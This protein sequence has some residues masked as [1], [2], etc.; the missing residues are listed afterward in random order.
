MRALWFLGLLLHAACA[1]GQLSAEDSS[2]L[3]NLL[4]ED[5]SKCEVHEDPIVAPT[6][7]ERGEFTCTP[8]FN[9]AEEHIVSDQLGEFDIRIGNRIGFEQFENETKLLSHSECP[10]YGDVCCTTVIPPTP[11]PTPPPTAEEVVTKC[12]RGDFNCTHFSR[13]AE[14][15]IV[16]DQLGNFDPRIGTR[17][18]LTQFQQDWQALR[19]SECTGEEEICCTKSMPALPPTPSYIPRCGRRNVDG[20]GASIG[21]F[22]GG[23]AQFGEF[24]WM[25]AVQQMETLPSGEQKRFFVCG[26]ALI[27]PQL[28]LTAAHCVHQLDAAS[29]VVRLGEWDFRNKMELLPHV[30]VGVS[31]IA[32]HPEYIRRRLQE[33]VAV[34]TLAEPVQLQPH[35]DT[36][37]LP[38]PDVDYDRA[39]CVAPGW[40][41]QFGDSGLFQAILK[42]TSWQHLPRAACMTELRKTP[43]LRKYFYLD[44]SFTCTGGAAGARSTPAE[45]TCLGG[46]GGSPLACR[47]PQRPDVWVQMGVVSWGIGCGADVAGVYADV[48]R[49]LAWIGEQTAKL[50]SQPGT[51]GSGLLDTRNPFK[52]Q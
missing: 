27:H 24:P 30:E 36:L 18:G 37:C 3:D 17:I 33:D 11:P 26:G 32:V 21:G 1:A 10:M 40:G 46:D 9:C 38:D 2:F 19:H 44:R 50:G 25:A 4:C 14:E 49:Q 43:H 20:I 8:Y 48:R 39:A 51:D 16:S 35:I 41:K 13:C 23:E 15:N 31:G 34:L 22:N 45:R 28:V 52:K 5:R 7:C 12:E 6:P 42:H 29:L 47:D